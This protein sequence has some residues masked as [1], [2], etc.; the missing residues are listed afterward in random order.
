MLTKEINEKNYNFKFGIRF[1]RKL[2]E[3]IKTE[4]NG[5]EFGVGASVKIAQL[6]N[7]NDITS[8]V[9]ILKVANETENQRLTVSQLEDWIDEVEDIDAL[10]DEVVEELKQSNATSGKMK[11]L[12]A[13]EQKAQ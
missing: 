11:A 2:D 3:S 9:D 10:A 8:L 12:A 6:A 1:V 13:A 4:Q 7:A 5:I